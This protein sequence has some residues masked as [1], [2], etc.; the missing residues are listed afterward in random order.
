MRGTRCLAVFVAALLAGGGFSGAVGSTG[1]GW[2]VGF[3]YYA[4]P[5]TAG[6]LDYDFVEVQGALSYDFGFA[7]SSLNYS[8]DVFGVKGAQS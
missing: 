5:G 3:I 8:P 2:D 7:S 1:L 4:Y 6:S